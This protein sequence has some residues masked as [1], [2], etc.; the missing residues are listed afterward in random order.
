MV[1][2]DST[3]HALESYVGIIGDLQDINLREAEGPFALGS[4]KSKIKAIRKA[5]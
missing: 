3:N 1:V 2:L 5:I 4:E